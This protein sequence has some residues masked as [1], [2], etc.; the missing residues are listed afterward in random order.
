MSDV[1]TVKSFKLDPRVI[2]EYRA[3]IDGEH[4]TGVLGK[5]LFCVSTDDLTEAKGDLYVALG[6]AKYLRRLGWGITLWPASRWA[7]ETPEDIDA[8][9]V[10]IESFVPGLVRTETKLIAWVRNWTDVWSALPYLDSFSQVWCS[11]QL[12]AERIRSVFDGAVE[13]VPLATDIEIFSS[14]DVERLPAVVTT[15]NFWGVN[16]TLISAL[17]A[18]ARTETV[19]W[20]GRNSRY[21]D[22]PPS[23]DHQDAISYFSLPAVYSHWQFVVDD[24]IEPAA[25]Y[26]NQNSRLFDALACG[27]LVVTNTP[28][29][30][31][32]LGL[33][34]T[35][36]YNENTT[37]VDLITDL[38]NNPTQTRERMARLT[39]V[40]RSRH[41]YEIRAQQVS[42]LLSE[43]RESSQ[44]TPVRSPL[45]RWATLRR[46]ELR[47]T[48]DA[49]NTLRQVHAETLQSFQSTREH[50]EL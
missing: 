48:D 36:S 14:T 15:T 6:L 31:A 23:V 11:S 26:G 49:H 5:L 3:L 46:E 28:A 35:P 17:S 50:H 42:V 45:L 30:L 44:I 20:F 37:L 34:Q 1:S 10:M 2:A 16:R 27:A 41:T 33:E 38:R 32:E 19:T 9:V 4:S 18:L 13:V 7:E 21:L 29:M 24:L 25:L 22:I 47:E 8:A 43:L 40:V 12:S 39:E